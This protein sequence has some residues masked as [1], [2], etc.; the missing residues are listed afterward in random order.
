M[1]MRYD[2][3]T[4]ELKVLIQDDRGGTS[5]VLDDPNFKRLIGMVREVKS[6]NVLGKRYTI[7]KSQD[8]QEFLSEWS[9]FT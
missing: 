3:K 8:G 5:Q 4:D 1:R 7:W 9:R 2:K 6:V